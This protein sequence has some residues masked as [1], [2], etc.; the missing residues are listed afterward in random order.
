MFNLSQYDI[1]VENVSRNP[2]PAT[3]Y[4]EAFQRDKGS[5]LSDTGTLIAYSGVKTG[6]SPKD[7]ES[8]GIPNRRTT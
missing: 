3:L 4:Q 2:S 6:R 8:S 1:E 7:N 5:T